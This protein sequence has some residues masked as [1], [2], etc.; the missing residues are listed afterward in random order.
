MSS[1]LLLVKII[2]KSVKLP[3]HS[4]HL[5]LQSKSVKDLMCGVLIWSILNILWQ[6][7]T[8]LLCGIPI[9]I[10]RIFLRRKLNFFLKKL[11]QMEIQRGFGPRKNRVRQNTAVQEN[12]V[13]GGVPYKT[14]FF[15]GVETQKKISRSAEP[16]FFSMSKPEKISAA[17]LKITSKVADY[18]LVMYLNAN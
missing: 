10:S 15:F 4:L 17:T 7:N 9:K 3:L 1:F 2:F 8:L 6:C 13:K 5:Y 12:R 16:D 11:R 14:S 18:C